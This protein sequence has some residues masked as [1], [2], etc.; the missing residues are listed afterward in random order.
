MAPQGKSQSLFCLA[1]GCP[2]S[3]PNQIQIQIQIQICLAPGCPN[4]QH[5]HQQSSVPSGLPCHICICM[6]ACVYV[7]VYACVCVCEC[8]CMRV[9]EVANVCVRVYE[10]VHTQYELVHTQ[11]LPNCHPTYENYMV[12]PFKLYTFAGQ[13]N[14][15][16][17]LTIANANI[18]TT[19]FAHA[20]TLRPAQAND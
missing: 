10:L 15:R 18:G 19:K 2:N 14:L 20:F 11:A 6:Y 7:C 17:N 1:P 5:H 12:I 9:Y 16:N 8:V 13:L 3:N 4:P